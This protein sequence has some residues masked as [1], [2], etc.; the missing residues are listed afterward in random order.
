MMTM[1]SGGREVLRSPQEALSSARCERCRGRSGSAGDLQ[2]G[3]A[4]GRASAVAG[5]GGSG[6]GRYAVRREERWERVW[7]CLV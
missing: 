3:A 2:A 4:E 7:A 6:D 5:R 1:E